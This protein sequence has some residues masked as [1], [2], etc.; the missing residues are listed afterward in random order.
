MLL[1][2]VSGEEGR[3]LSLLSETSGVTDAL[4]DLTV[5]VLELS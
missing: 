3:V 5:Y 1:C 4:L 2:E